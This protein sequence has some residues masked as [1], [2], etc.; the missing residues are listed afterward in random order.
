M[1]SGAVSGMM[2][3]E[4]QLFLEA[5]ESY[6]WVWFY[7]N[8]QYYKKKKKDYFIAAEL[9][10]L[11]ANDFQVAVTGVVGW[12]GTHSGSQCE[13]F[14]LLHAI[15]PATDGALVSQVDPL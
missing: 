6:T 5:L 14:A 11:Q 13:C 1:G 2:L 10:I 4:C 15:A 9:E 12:V 7:Q 8:S 3:N